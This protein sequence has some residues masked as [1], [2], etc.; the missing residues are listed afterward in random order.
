MAQDRKPTSKQW[1]GSLTDDLE[2]LSSTTTRTP[3]SDV[4]SAAFSVASTKLG[5]LIEQLKG[6]KCGDGSPEASPRATSTSPVYGH[7]LRDAVVTIGSDD[8]PGGD[9]GMGTLPEVE[10][11]HGLSR[12]ERIAQILKSAKQQRLQKE[13]SS[14]G[15]T[16]PTNEKGS[17]P[18]VLPD[19]VARFHSKC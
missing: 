17:N 4:S 7:A 8:K 5:R 13:A 6:L 18:H 19:H 2:E 11:P 15:D 9:T 14:K 10:P 3:E 1:S 16:G 12:T